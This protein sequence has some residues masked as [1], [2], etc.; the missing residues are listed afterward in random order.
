MSP[1]ILPVKQIVVMEDRAQVE[2]RGELLVRPGAGPV[3][4]AGVS[5]LAVDRS[6]QVEVR[7]AR[8]IDARL[9][10]R[11]RVLPKGGLPE[12]ASALRRQ[13]DHLEDEVVAKADL[14]AR[15]EAQVELL[16]VARVDLLRAVAEHTGFGKAD[17]TGWSAQLTALSTRQRDGDETLR[18]ARLAL[19]TTQTRLEEARAALAA[20]EERARDLE[21]FLVLTLDGDGPAEV[22]ARY[23]V[24]CAA[25]RPA[26]RAS[27]TGDAVRL[28]AEAV[29]WQA[30]GE[31][32]DDVQLTFS[33]ARPTLG[34]SPP[35]LTEDRLR[36]RAKLHEEKRVIDVAVR[37]EERQ[38]A[39]EGGE[40]EL[41]GLDDGGEA[42]RL[43]ASGRH[44]VL[45]D[46]Q[47]HRVPLFSF[48]SKALLERVCPAELTPL[49]SLVARFPNAS[50]QVLLA[51][52]VDL[53]RQSGYVGRSQLAFAAPG[54]LVKVSFGSEDGLRLVRS[55]EEKVDEARLTGRRT[56]TR[57]VTLHVS[58]ARGE[59]SRLVI[60]ERIPVSEVKEVEIQVLAKECSPPP[61]VI[62]KDG[63]ARI[64]LEL[65]AHGT[66]TARFAWELSAAGKVAGV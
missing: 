1:S 34:S 48:E 30:T 64:E 31:R 22:R 16:T 43:T 5:T 59:P 25:W 18:Q 10:R 15:A 50:G 66:K 6:L 40:P 2:R 47:P 28:E 51:G 65:P 17:V 35:S 24:P 27:L 36:T 29:V 19:L 63:I 56:T 61:S 52:P 60:E 41:P 57:V 12:D 39:G 20:S 33:T 49:T 46:G 38:S 3:E 45:T 62:T 54:E 42:Q 32:W 9:D 8:F 7:G 58:N 26:Y 21:C 11:W 37:E 13:V 23:L 55:T 44:A 53:V 14:V 4:I